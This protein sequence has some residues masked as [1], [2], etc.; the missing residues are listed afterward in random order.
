VV[1]HQRE[2]GEVGLA[3]DH[4]AGIDESGD[5]GRVGGGNAIVEHARRAGRGGAAQIAE[6][7][8]RD[9]NP[10]Q[11]SAP[12][13]G[14]DLGLGGTRRGECRFGQHG[15]IGVQGGIEPLDACQH[16]LGQ[17]HRRQR[18]GGD[19]LGGVSE[20]QPT[21]VVGRHPGDHRRR[22]RAWVADLAGTLA[23]G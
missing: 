3:D 20:R 21:Q 11:R 9:R 8:R 5:T 7:L 15:E 10:V 23:A 18:A 16:R 6:I 14:D 22:R 1:A 13:A 19:A 4:R 12:A 17:I 2:L